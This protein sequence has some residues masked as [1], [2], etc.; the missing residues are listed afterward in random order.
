MDTTTEQARQRL[1]EVFEELDRLS[2]SDD[3]PNQVIPAILQA[4][5]RALDAAGGCAWMPKD[6]ANQT[7]QPIGIVGDAR[8]LV[9]EAGENGP[10]PRTPVLGAVRKAFHDDKPVVVGPEQNEFEGTPLHDRTQLFVPVHAIG[11]PMALLHMV[12]DRQVDPK[13]YREHVGVCQE[14]TRA[15]GTYLGKRQN[16][17][18]QKDTA[19]QAALLR[20]VHHLMKFR[21]PKVVAHE[22]ANRARPLLEAQRVAVVGL[23]S[24]SQPVAFSDAVHL[25]QRAVLVRTAQLLAEVARDR[26]APLSYTR[27]QALHGEDEPVRPLLDDLFRLSNAEAVSLVPIVERGEV[28]GVLLA[29][30]ATRDEVGTRS[31]YQQELARQAG[32]I[33][34]GAIA[35]HRRPLRRTS[36]LLAWVRDRPAMA[37]ARAGVAVGIVATLVVVLFFV[38]VPLNIHADARLSPVN[39]RTVAAPVGQEIQRVL[40]ESGES[41]EKG[42]PLLE[43]DSSA[44]E[45]KRSQTRSAIAKQKVRLD[46]ARAEG[47]DAAIRRAELEIRRLRLKEQRLSRKIA[48][49]EIQS[50]MAGVVLD[51]R[52]KRL[53]GQTVQ[54]GKELLRIGDLES[55][56]L[57]MEVQEEDLALLE[58]AVERHKGKADGVRVEFLSRAWPNKT[59]TGE[60]PSFSSLSPTSVPSESKRQHIFEVR[61]PIDLDQIQPKFAMA[62]PSGRA[63]LHVGQSSLAYRIGRGPWRFLKMTLMF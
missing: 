60:A 50:P 48:R 55:F 33:L 22:L 19:S 62:N 47:K 29:E 3:L 39:L 35:W 20:V 27:D 8:D 40:V 10:A 21:D 24:R 43:L 15:L 61:V 26:N 51:D 17:L 4:T 2:R 41:V 52:P 31:P 58:R 30:H 25:N 6:S 7:F 63:K 44:L 14:G 53:E 36:D 23:W 13:T 56:E 37:L 57:V 34:D 42:D 49:C 28:L 1:K 46:A 11:R 32:P 45:M 38:P 16:T 5:R 18:L 54:K 9:L 59:L 12:L